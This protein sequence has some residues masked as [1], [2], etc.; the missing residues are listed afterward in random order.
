MDKL[1]ILQEV[2][3]NPKT[4]F[5]N[6][7]KIY[8]RV[9]GKGITLKEVREFIKNQDVSQIHKPVSRHEYYPIYSG[10]S[11]AYQADLMFY[12]RYKKKNRGYAVILTCI[13]INTRKGYAIALKNKQPDEVI[14]GFK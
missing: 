7:N 6:A 8:Q 10:K 11:G 9:K 2:Y 14:R 1:Q 12:Y 5:G 13:N 4:G 3:Y